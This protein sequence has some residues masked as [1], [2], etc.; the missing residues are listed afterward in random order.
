MGRSEAK[1]KDSTSYSVKVQGT[2]THVSCNWTHLEWCINI[3]AG[4]HWVTS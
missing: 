4:N 2:G 3:V 1:R